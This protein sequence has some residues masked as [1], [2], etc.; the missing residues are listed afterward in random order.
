M[1]FVYHTINAY[2]LRTRKPTAAAT[3]EHTALHL[4]QAQDLRIAT[5]KILE[6]RTTFERSATLAP[7]ASLGGL[8]GPFSSLQAGYG[9]TQQ[10]PYNPGLGNPRGGGAKGTVTKPNA[11]KASTTDTANSLLDR[12]GPSKQRGCRRPPQVLGRKAQALLRP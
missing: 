5:A 7:P 4:L 11:A 8:A 2:E 6:E 12:L 9:A 3:A 10:Q 1:D